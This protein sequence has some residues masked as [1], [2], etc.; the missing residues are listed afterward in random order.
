MKVREIMSENPVS[1]TPD[2][3][4]RDVAQMMREHDIGAIPVIERNDA[5]RPVGVVTDR[6]ITVRVV[7]EGRN[8]LEASARDAMTGSVVTV[9]PDASI[10]EC[11][12]LME[13]NQVRR[14]LVVDESGS[15]RGIVALADIAR[16][17]HMGADLV[18]G[19]SEPS[20]EASRPAGR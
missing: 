5:G 4:L 16:H 9:R 1:C 17:T 14:I 3:G 6:D 18:E 20:R 11:A 7:A 19:V 8:P 2:T 10:D 15:C 12:E 13:R